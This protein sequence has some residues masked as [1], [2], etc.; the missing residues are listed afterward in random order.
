MRRRDFIA[1]IGSTAVLPVVAHAQHVERLRRVALFLP[2][3]IDDA[4]FQ[5]RITA[6][7]E[8]LQ[9]AGWTIGRTVRIDTHW[10]TANASAI[11]K[12]AAKLVAQAPDVIVAFGAATVRV[13][14]A[15]TRT[16]PIAFCGVG[17]PVGAG[18]VES[19][20]RPG[21]NATGLMAFEYGASGRWLELLKE[22]APRLARAAVLQNPGTPSMPQFRVIQAA[23]PSLGVDVVPINVGDDSEIERA[24]A[25]FARAPNGGLI[26]TTGEAWAARYQRLIVM[27]AAR[28][29]LPAVYFDRSFVAAG[30]LISYG[31][32]FIDQFRQAADCVDRILKG[33]KAAELPVQAPTKYETAI[34][35][36]T[37]EAL[38]LTVPPKLLARAD[39]VIR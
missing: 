31:P 8:G 19:L 28:H 26:A 37:A 3:T 39:D 29:K 1:A 10:A 11:R 25:A 14:L 17:D 33:E 22:I 32:D 20:A 12:H 7:H 34:N 18:L 24:V 27:M 30:G 21:G 2:A 9:Q 38:G 6:F 16:I 13:L 35:L 15:A 5:L 4:H 36:K 23:A